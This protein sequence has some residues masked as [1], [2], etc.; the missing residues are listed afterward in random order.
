MG[1]D[2]TCLSNKRLAIPDGWR[3]VT[4][5]HAASINE[6]SIQRGY[7]HKVIEYIDVA[8]VERGVIQSVQALSLSEAPSRAKRIV[9]DND[10]LISTVRPNLEHYTFI[11]RAKPNTIASTGF[12]VV[13][14]KR[15]DPRYLYYYLTSKLFTAYLSQIADSH[16]SAYPAIN[17]DVIETAEL[18]LPPLPE[19]RAI[20]HILGTLDDK[21]ELNRRMNQ[22]LEA[23]VQALFKNWFVDF[24]PFRDQGMQDSPLG[25]IPV[26]WRVVGIKDI[27]ERVGMGPFGSSIK[28][29][30]FVLEGIPI[31]SGQ[32]LNQTLLEDNHYNFITPL[33][34]EALRNSNVFRGDIIFTHAG[35]I[36]QVAYIPETSLYE[37]YVIS[38]RQFYLRCDLT[39]ISPLFVVYFFKTLQGQHALL[40][41]TSST[42]VPSISQPVSYLKTIRLAI[43]PKPLID[44][45][46][47]IIREFHLQIANNVYQSKTLSTIRNTLLPK[48][49]S[50]K[51]RVKDAERFMGGKK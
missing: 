24:E 45:F 17:Q 35:N 36:G 14:A 43:P 37:R 8:S 31:I 39:K 29:E 27:A 33:H 50:G 6:L 7:P 34:A 25:E 38:Q 23:M 4:V 41:N 12:A 5:G 21:I 30:T 1:F 2:Y 18:V 20:A 22:T 13:S 19:Q 40:A 47:R 44:E 49:L 16:T 28:I 3:V 48:L 42:G 9:R 15:V 51:I 26:G 10:I 46:D 32:H 11:K